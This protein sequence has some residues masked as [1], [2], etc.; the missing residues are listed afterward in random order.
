VSDRASLVRVYILEKKITEAAS[1][2][3][4]AE[5]ILG[6]DVKPDN[7]TGFVEL[8]LAK[9]CL[10][11]ALKQFEVA[12]DCYKKALPIYDNGQT[13]SPERPPPIIRTEPSR[14]SSEDKLKEVT[15]KKFR[16]K[17]AVVIVVSQFKDSDIKLNY[18]SDDA[19]EFANY[20]V[21]EANFDREHVNLLRDE[22]A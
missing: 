1:E 20:L 9:G 21:R 6:Q 19:L 7:S 4:S 12:Q 14:A 5:D 15:T 2:E 10:N 3:K 16:H 22:D 8:L 18:A 13:R 11:D 17:Y